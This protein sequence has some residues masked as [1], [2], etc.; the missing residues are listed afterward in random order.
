MGDDERQGVF[1]LRANMD[2]MD[3]ESVDLGD[4]LRQRVEPRLAP[5]PVVVRP[6]IARDFLEG[7]QLYALGFIGDRLFVRPARHRD[8]PAEIGQRLVGDMDVEDPDCVVLGRF[9]SRARSGW[10][11]GCCARR[12]R[13]DQDFAPGGLG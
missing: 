6:P 9:G 4:E 10:K 12:R 7:R 3:V 1:M 11:S 5:A 13:G 8:T 2:E